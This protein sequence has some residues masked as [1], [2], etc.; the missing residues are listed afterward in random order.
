MT[1]VPWAPAAAIFH[2][3]RWEYLHGRMH[4]AGYALDPEYMYS[5]DGG[6]LDVATMSGLIEVVERLSLLH[7]IKCAHDPADAATKLTVDSLQVPPALLDPPFPALHISITPSLT[8]LLHHPTHRCRLRWVHACSSFQHSD[9]RRASSRRS[10][11]WIMQRLYPRA[12]GGART[13]RT[14]LLSSA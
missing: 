14:Y 7:I 2:A 12:D 11:S 3:K 9:I 6:P 10:L 4:S 1:V 5:S 13:A 8:S